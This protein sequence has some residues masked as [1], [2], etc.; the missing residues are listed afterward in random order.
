[1]EG[2][3]A[4]YPT[5]ADGHRAHSEC[6]AISCG[7]GCSSQMVLLKS[8]DCDALRGDIWPN[9]PVLFVE[10]GYHRITPFRVFDRARL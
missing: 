4:T 3:N 2:C 1:M 7:A 5:T 10:G 6:L 8:L 9:V